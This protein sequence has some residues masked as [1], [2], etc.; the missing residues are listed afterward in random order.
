[1][2]CFIAISSNYIFGTLLTANGS[3]KSLNYIAFTGMVMNIVLNFILIPKY[4][5]MGSAWASLITQ[6]FTALAQFYISVRVFS[7]KVNRKLIIQFVLFILV[8][9]TIMYSLSLSDLNVWLQV[10]IATVLFILL[11]MLTGIFSP[12]SLKKVLAG[13]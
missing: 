10:G 7:F 13:Q 1:M 2:F 3:L 11:V 12:R 6:I 9:F 4:Q 5:V 8:L